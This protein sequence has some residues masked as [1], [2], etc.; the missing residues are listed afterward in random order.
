VVVVSPTDTEI[1]P[2]QEGD[3]GGGDVGGV[4][5]RGGEQ[6][7]LKVLWGSGVQVSFTCQKRPIT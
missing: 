4:G 3:A 2:Q 6:L 1:L 7:R 5:G